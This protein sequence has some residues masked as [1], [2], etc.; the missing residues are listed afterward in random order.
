[1][2]LADEVGAVRAVVAVGVAG[3]VD[4]DGADAVGLDAG[5]P[6]PGCG[7]ATLLDRAAAD[8][9]RTLTFRA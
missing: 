3:V 1:V 4:D 8:R 9:L 2:D 5:T 6:P 7:S